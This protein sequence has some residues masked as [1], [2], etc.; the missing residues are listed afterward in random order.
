MLGQDRSAPA[1]LACLHDLAR[2]TQSLLDESRP[3][4]AGVKDVRLGI[5]IS[6]IQAYADKIV[7]LLQAR[8]P[9][10]ERVHLKAHE[11]LGHGMLGVVGELT[12]RML[13][14]AAFSKRAAGA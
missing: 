7:R 1:L 4:A 6:V 8:D 5:D 2:R 10:C 11:F 13:G 9:L 3:L 12:R 14:R